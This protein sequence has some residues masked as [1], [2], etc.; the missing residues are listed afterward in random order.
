MNTQPPPRHDVFGYFDHECADPTRPAHDP[1]VGGI[2]AVCAQR[3]GAHDVEANPIVTISLMLDIER[4]GDRSYFFRV[5]K[6][7]WNAATDEEKSHIESSLIDNIAANKPT[8]P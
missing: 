8:Q 3:V 4:V 1:G 7:C 5:H 2:C 6:R